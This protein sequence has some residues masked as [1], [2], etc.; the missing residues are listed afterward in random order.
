MKPPSRSCLPPLLHLC[1]CLFCSPIPPREAPAA[2]SIAVQAPLIAIATDVV[3]EYETHCAWHWWQRRRRNNPQPHHEEMNPQPTAKK[4]PAAP[5]PEES[6]ISATSRSPVDLH[7]LRLPTISIW[8]EPRPA[9]LGSSSWCAEGSSPR[10]PHEEWG[11]V[12]S[13]HNTK[14]ENLWLGLLHDAQNPIHQLFKLLTP[15]PNQ[16]RLKSIYKIKCQPLRTISIQRRVIFFS[17]SLPN[18]QLL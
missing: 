1:R 10:V 5:T 18:R 4:V 16:A 7:S 14:N 15:G 13:V 2:A 17:S 9:S 12:Q 6:T 11:V 3:A 8:I